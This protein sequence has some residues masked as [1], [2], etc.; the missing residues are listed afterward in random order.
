MWTLIY[1]F[2]KVSFIPILALPPKTFANWSKQGLVLELVPPKFPAQAASLLVTLFPFPLWDLGLPRSRSLR[3]L[4]Y[5]PHFP[6]KRNGPCAS[7]G[8]PWRGDDLD[9]RTDT[10]E[11]TGWVENPVCKISYTWQAEARFLVTNLRLRMFSS[12][13]EV[14]NCYLWEIILQGP[15]QN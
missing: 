9:H 3:G 8:D 13:P 10:E 6:N 11:G 14:I 4:P 15:G 2:L 1:Y 7:T 12:S 5:T